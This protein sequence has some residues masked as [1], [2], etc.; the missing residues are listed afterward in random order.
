M[1]LT[2]KSKYIAHLK[3]FKLSAVAIVIEDVEKAI[4]DGCGE[5]IQLLLLLKESRTP[6][7]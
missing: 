4:I 5:R 1:S 2:N 3:D 6:L 7:K